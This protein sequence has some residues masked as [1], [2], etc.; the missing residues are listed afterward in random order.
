MIQI[1]DY[2]AGNLKSVANAL[3][4]LGFNYEIIGTPEK[5][6]DD[7]KIIFPGV[8][9]AGSAMLNLRK[10][11]FD[12]VIPTLRNPFLGICLGMQLLLDYSEEDDTKCLGV[13]NGK[14]KKF[15]GDIKVPQIGWNT[16]SDEQNDELFAGIADENYFYFL[17][18]YYVDCGD[19]YVLGR[20]NYGGEFVSAV[21]M[22]NFYG[23]Q[24]HPE[25]SGEIGLKLL[26]NFCER[27]GLQP[28]PML[29]LPAIDII[30]GK[31]VRL[32]KGD[33]SQVKEYSANPCEVAR[34]FKEA[35]AEMLHVVDLDGAR[36]GRI[37]NMNI[38]KELVG[39]GLP[40]QVGGGIRDYE[41]AKKLLNLDVS[42]IILGT[43][44]VNDQ[45]LLKRLIAEFGADRVVI[46]VDIK[47]GK[48]A[49][50]GWE[51]VSDVSVEDF[52]EKLG[53]LGV[54]TII[55]TDISRDGMLE[56]VKIKS[57]PNGFE[58]IVAGGVT[59]IEDIVKLRELGAGGVIIGKALYEGKIDLNQAIKC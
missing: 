23:V 30:G 58:V 37:V 56:G 41:S 28:P 1:I 50:K 39:V 19:R 34:K 6:R 44:A 14:V 15:T 22:G 55:V 35:G 13:I 48:I 9:A 16:V 27:V 32:T 21:K 17:N 53:E 7:A 57:L 54:E 38:I 42:R 4:K 3:E 11:G 36:E 24:F 2:G 31:C 33:Y 45:D 10:S 26:S 5:L 51:E 49:V 25:K 59:S 47:D 12:K 18:S 29:I 8:G 46:S 43:A 52:L 40:I 20:S